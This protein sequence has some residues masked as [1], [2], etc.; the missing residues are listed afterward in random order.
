MELSLEGELRGM[1]GKRGPDDTPFREGAVR[2]VRESGKS[3]AEVARDLG[4]REGTLQ[5]W[6]HRARVRADAEAAGGL[7]E[8]VREELF[9][10]REENR[11]LR[12]E[13]TEIGMERDVLKRSVVLWVM[14][15]TK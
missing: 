8:S 13:N 7:E 11:Q 4:V 9:R 10:L 1:A 14:E 15:T 5:T 3:A 12:R 6:V 2:V